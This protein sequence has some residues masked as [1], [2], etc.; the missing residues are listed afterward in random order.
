MDVGVV[1]SSTI[2]DGRSTPKHA[3]KTVANSRAKAKSWNGNDAV[4][5]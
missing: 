2:F 1:E 5:Q 4:N 3:V